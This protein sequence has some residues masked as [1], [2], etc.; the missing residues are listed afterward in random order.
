M[1]K[2]PWIGMAAAAAYVGYNVFKLG[3]QLDE[4]FNKFENFQK[5]M[6]G[7]SLK[8]NLWDR[9]EWNK[10][11]G[12]DLSGGLPKVKLAE[13]PDPED[14]KKKAKAAADAAKQ[15][16]QDAF[17]DLGVKET[18]RELDELAK[19]FA[20]VGR[21]LKGLDQFDAK[22]NALGKLRDAQERKTTE[23]GANLGLVRSL[24]ITQKEMKGYIETLHDTTGMQDSLASSSAAVGESLQDSVGKISEGIVQ[25]SESQAMAAATASLLNQK[26]LELNET[27]QLISKTR[28]E[29]NF[30]ALFGDLQEASSEKG[31]LKILGVSEDRDLTRMG[32]ALNTLQGAYEKGEISVRSL[33]RATLNYYRAALEQ[34]AKLTPQQERHRQELEKQVNVVSRMQR[35]W[36]G[37]TQQ[38]SSIITDF[39]RGVLDILFPKN[40]GDQNSRITDAFR[41][42]FDKLSAQGFSNPN[43]GLKTIIANIKTATSVA[44]ANRIALAAFG[45]IGPQIARAL[46]DGS[47]EGDRLA[48]SLDKASVS[49]AKLD[50]GPTKLSKFK[51]LLGEVRTA[52]LRAF[53]EE[54]AKA[55]SDFVGKHLKDLIN[56]L[57]SVLVKI[58]IIGKGLAGIFGN[59]AGKAGEVA[60]NQIPG[61]VGLPPLPTG[62]GGSIPSGGG[63]GGAAGGAAQGGLMSTIGVVSGVASAVSSII[64]NFQMFGMNKSL[65]IIV[66]HTLQT[67]NDLAN[68][69]ADE[70]SRETHLMLKLD[71]VWNEVRNVTRN[72]AAMLGGVT[73]LPTNGTLSGAVFNIYLP[74]S[75]TPNSEESEALEVWTR[76]IRREGLRLA[77]G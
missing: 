4:T 34:G 42:A 33:N 67:A 1:T 7:D 70:W 58:P 12:E 20:L 76:R 15:A 66:K 38:I 32:F 6:G 65:D 60:I 54:G 24:Q 68:L 11:A 14:L 9:P 62:P 35:A 73:V 51:A 56:G 63:A 48:E 8:G 30:K 36:R 72:T 47:L 49:I 64:G 25:A 10:K 61:N 50:E 69:R 41:D 22:A 21:S 39:S 19:S 2:L 31:A 43:Q 75:F 45:D 55:I 52:I 3:N 26:W 37:V 59:T 18:K 71:D 53:V 28:A 40:A 74:E 46:R 44:E 13:L 77:R 5:K 57:D 27:G 17:S 23:P 16:W 29:S